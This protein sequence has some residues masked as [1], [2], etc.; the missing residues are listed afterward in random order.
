MDT[1][2]QIRE[3]MRAALKAR[4]WTQQ[5]LADH[6]GVSKSAIAQLLSGAYGKVPSSLLEALDVLGLELIAAPRKEG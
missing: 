3:A 4:G 1:D 2:A 5:Q 6:L